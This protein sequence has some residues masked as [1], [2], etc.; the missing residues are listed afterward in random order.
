MTGELINYLAFRDF[1]PRWRL[2]E[3]CC[4]VYTRPTKVLT[5]RSRPILPV[6]A[7]QV[8]CSLMIVFSN[9]VV[10]GQPRKWDN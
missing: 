6:F 10:L 1:A 7:V 4:G 5:A 8:L 3:G 9:G 2:S